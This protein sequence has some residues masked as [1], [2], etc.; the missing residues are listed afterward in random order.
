LSSDRA[1][2]LTLIRNIAILGSMVRYFGYTNGTHRKYKHMTHTRTSS[3]TD[4]TP[5]KSKT[6]PRRYKTSTLT[7]LQKMSNYP[8]C[9]LSRMRILADCDYMPRI[10]VYYQYHR[11]IVHRIDH[12]NI[13]PRIPYG[14]V[15]CGWGSIKHSGRF[16]GILS[17][18]RVF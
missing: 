17:V 13:P 12:Q 5:E 9:P 6:P 8:N 4:F 2:T 10:I 11:S 16:T 18:F 14:G 7:L 3:K 1:E 15:F